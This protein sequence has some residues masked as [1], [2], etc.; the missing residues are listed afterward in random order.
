ML[1]LIAC[2]VVAPQAAYAQADAGQRPAGERRVTV[3]VMPEGVDL[4]TL[5]AIPDAAVA[6]MSGGIGGTPAAQTYLDISQGART[7]DSVYPE[8]V[9]LVLVDPVRGVPPAK[10]RIVERRAR[11]APAQI[12]PG[13]LGSVLQAAGVETR[14]RPE[15]GNAGI[16]AVNRAGQLDLQPCRACPGLTVSSGNLAVAVEHALALRPDDLLIAFERPPADRRDQLSLAI[17]GLGKGVLHSDST[18][19][20]GYVLA[21]DLAPTILAHL[22][23]E[24][25]G[26]MA[27]RVLSVNPDS[28]LTAVRRL[29]ERMGAVGER[30]PDVLGTNILIWLGLT[31]LAGALFRRRG[32]RVAVPLLAVAIAYLPTVLLVT[33]ALR[34]SAATEQL[35]A[36]LLPPL[37]ALVTL[38]LLPGWGALGFS[39]GLAAAAHAI[40]VVVGSPLTSLSLMG[41]NPALGVRFFGIGNELESALAALL[42]VGVGAGLAAWWPAATPAQAAAAFAVAALLG[43]AA[44][45]PGRFGAD[46]GA[47][48]VIPLGAA[49]AVAAYAG[50]GRRR[51][52]LILAA[53]VA[54][55]AV[56]MAVDLALGGDAHLSR[57]VLEAGGFDEVGDVVERRLRL[58]AKSFANYS[59]SIA[60]WFSVAALIAGVIWRRRVLGWFD[61][62][63]ARA[64]FLGAAA[65]TV[66]GTVANDSGALIL[67]VGTAVTSL[68]AAYAW[69]ARRA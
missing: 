42:L 24:V 45:A 18:R 27:G 5:S 39:A 58:S 12:E 2:A 8:D 49:V 3:L 44:Y 66:V 6:L 52:L 63:A 19:R 56:L 29:E 15:A 7:N 32:L 36:G 30:R 17:V 14:A 57:S 1:A 69:A 62:P 55:L 13:L 54:A 48:I 16:I 11:E 65:A 21:T 43:V 60:L 38:R 53:P 33:A 31:M 50:A 10:W 41:P 22:G 34:P 47:A 59:D 67:M 4:A 25:P 51:T 68:C 37:L 40:D 28:D 9:P 20:D 64:G 61:H 35:I 46:V 23:L 26:A